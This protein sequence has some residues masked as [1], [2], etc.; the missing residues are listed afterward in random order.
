[1]K[2]IARRRTNMAEVI[3]KDLEP[4]YCVNMAAATVKV[5][6]LIQF[7]SL[8]KLGGDTTSAKIPPLTNT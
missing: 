4:Q 2:K 8:Q 3:S 7:A 5:T 1:M 6:V